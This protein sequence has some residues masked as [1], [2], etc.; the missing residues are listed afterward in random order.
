MIGSQLETHVCTA[1]RLFH[2]HSMMEVWLSSIIDGWL[3]GNWTHVYQNGAVGDGR[4]VTI[5]SH[6]CEVSMW[7]FL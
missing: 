6:P 3:R 4:V 1:V 2:I 5:S 7:R